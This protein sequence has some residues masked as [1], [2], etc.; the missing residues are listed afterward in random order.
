M[1]LVP[2]ALKFVI[3]L[4]KEVGFEGPVM[5]LGNQDIWATYD[6][7]K[8]FFRQMDCSFREVEPIKNTSATLKEV[9][10]YAEDFVHAQVFFEMMGI[11]EYYDMDKYDFDK[12]RLLHDLNAPISE[13]LSDRFSVVVESGT[14]E[15]VFDVRS[16]MENIVRM[17]LVGGWV[18][19]ISPSSNF[20][21]HGFYSF[22][23]CFF[24]DF[25]AANGFEDF[26]CYI[27]EL[28]T[29]PMGYFEPCP[30]LEYTYGMSITRFLDKSKHI[31]VFF[32]ARKARSCELIQIPTQGMYDVERK[33][34]VAAA[35]S[36]VCVSPPASR[37]ERWIPKA[38]Q[39]LLQPLR[40][41][42]GKI[43]TFVFPGR[44]PFDKSVL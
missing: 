9:I 40:P 1:G 13:N 4:H 12:P 38:L 42:L 17:L 3:R 16:V 5:T 37:Y 25:Y 18:V 26:R 34:K 36:S 14:M 30:Y 11:D 28:K 20:I 24:H 39:P 15:H 19:H 10:P 22:S 44:P 32:A 35:P 7:L 33:V 6:D 27:F 23:P 41:V 21:D 43:W 8:S 2:T 29:N 31:L